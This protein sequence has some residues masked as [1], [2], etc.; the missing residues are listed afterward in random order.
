MADD[1]QPSRTRRQN[2]ERSGEDGDGGGRVSRGCA[3]RWMVERVCGVCGVKG[4]GYECITNKSG[5]ARAD[6]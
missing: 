6:L 2:R 3:R 5:I 1:H 4:K